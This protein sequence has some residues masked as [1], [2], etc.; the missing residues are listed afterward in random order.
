[1][2]IFTVDAGLPARPLNARTAGFLPL[3]D[4]T[5]NLPRRCQA[6]FF[7]FLNRGMLQ[8]CRTTVVVIRMCNKPCTSSCTS[9]Y[10]DRGCEIYRLRPSHFFEK[11]PVSSAMRNAVS[12]SDNKA[13]GKRNRQAH[14]HRCVQ[15]SDVTL[16]STTCN[17]ES[18]DS[19]VARVSLLRRMLLLG[20]PSSD[21]VMS[22]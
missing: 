10:I 4:M 19:T 1:M 14:Q 17:S 20:W 9:R 12:L 2:D 5:I 11:A 13:C 6:L 22:Q 15:C 3:V 18:L 8:T 16:H 7:R 21:T